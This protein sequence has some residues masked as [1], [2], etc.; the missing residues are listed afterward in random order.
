L[1]MSGE[2]SERLK[3]RDWKSRGRFIAAS[4]VRIPPSPLRQAQ[5]GGR[6][7]DGCGV[8]W[9]MGHQTPQ[10]SRSARFW[11][12]VKRQHGVVTR[13]QLLSLG[14]TADAVKHRIWTGRLH[15]VR[16]GVYAVGRSQ[17]SCHGIWMAAVLS[18]GSRAVLSH[19]SA[20]ALWGIRDQE[21]G[22]IEVSVPAP[23]EPLRP[24]IV[25]HRRAG[26]RSEHVTARL[27]VPV[28]TLVRTLVDMA[29]HL[30]ADQLERA[31]N[32]ADKRDLTNPEA[33][34]AALDDFGRGPGA[35]ILRRTLDRRTFMITDSELERRLLPLARKAG[36][37]APQTGASVNG[38]R[39]DFYWPDLGLVVETDG[40]RYH[41][42]PAQQ[43]R[44]RMR[45]QAHAAAGLTTLRFTHA[46]VTGDPGHVQATLTAVA[47][48]LQGGK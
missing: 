31:V 7:I 35:G 14:Y 46:Q 21:S 25:V 47:H 34:R 43:A 48:R 13:G 45:D 6:K 2:V 33:L 40:L 19:V 29:M 32:E 26:L 24:G 8:W 42:T 44:D 39:V 1:P 20:A 22:P 17:L 3:E 10:A 30:P 41:R 28:T 38:Y 36:L 18:C 5:A 23:R 27:G 37:S 4:R 15:P 9:V 16:R 11:A 12:L